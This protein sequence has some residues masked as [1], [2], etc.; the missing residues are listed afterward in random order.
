MHRYGNVEALCGRRV[1]RLLKERE[2]NEHIDHR[3]YRAYR[4]SIQI[5][6]AN[7]HIEAYASTS[8]PSCSLCSSHIYKHASTHALIEYVVVYD[9][10]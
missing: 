10:D 4:N 5:I 3:S 8:T 6:E 2:D 9:V 1:S 7:E